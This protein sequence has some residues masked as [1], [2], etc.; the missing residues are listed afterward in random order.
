MPHLASKKYPRRIDCITFE[1]CQDRTAFK[2]DL[3]FVFSALNMAYV[4]AERYTDGNGKPL[5]C[6]FDEV[7]VSQ[8]ISMPVPKGL[9]ML[10]EFNHIIQDMI[11]AGLLELW[12]KEIKQ[13]ATL[14][15]AK[16]FR[17]STGEYN[18]L[19]L[20]HLQSPFYFLFLGYALSVTTFIA[21]LI[22]RWKCTRYCN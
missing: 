12:L 16:D 17:L 7:I 15:S 22:F 2:G 19:T 1:E 5:I 20:E 3:A 11:E 4:T 21:E 8:I 14:T 9:P 13:T 10:D 6:T 18:K